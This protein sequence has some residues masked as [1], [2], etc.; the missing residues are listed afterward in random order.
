MNYGN[1]GDEGRPRRDTAPAISVYFINDADHNPPHK[2]SCMFCKRTILDSVSGRIDKMIDTPLPVAEDFGLA[3]N[4]Q[5][6]LC[7]QKWRVLGAPVQP[8][9][10]TAT[11][12]I[13]KS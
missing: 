12:A 9:L 11:D 2:L 3:L 8:F 6:K 4:V 10:P 1:Y 5:C 7:G 13:A